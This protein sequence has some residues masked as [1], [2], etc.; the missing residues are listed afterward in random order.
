MDDFIFDLNYSSLPS[1][2]VCQRVSGVR[3]P[4]DDFI[5]LDAVKHLPYFNSI[6]NPLNILSRNY[7]DYLKSIRLSTTA[8]YEQRFKKDSNAFIKRL[9]S[10]LN[11][12]NALLKLD[13]LDEVGYTKGIVIDKQVI[14]YMHEI[15][16]HYDFPQLTLMADR[17]MVADTITDTIATS[18]MAIYIQDE[19]GIMDLSAN[20][21]NHVNKNKLEI[22]QAI[23]LFEYNIRLAEYC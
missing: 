7:H 19:N 18:N 9:A 13:G 1:L 21:S 15:Y 14:Y 17:V 6:R 10:N 5:D 4:F 20:F 16:R 12:L 3:L 2:E 8:E 23:W 11:H 22:E